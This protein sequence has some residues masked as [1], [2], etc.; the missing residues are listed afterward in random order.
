M[1]S[2]VWVNADYGRDFHPLAE[3]IKSYEISQR[4]KIMIFHH[5]DF[6]F[7]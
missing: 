7:N 3:H 2:T 6:H 1:V 5:F 4:K